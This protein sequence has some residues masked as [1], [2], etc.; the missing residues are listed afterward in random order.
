MSMSLLECFTSP[1]TKFLTGL[2][3]EQ[4]WSAKSFRS[5]LKLA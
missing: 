1:S 2:K 3:T 5:G 4:L